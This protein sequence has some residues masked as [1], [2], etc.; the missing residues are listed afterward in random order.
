MMKTKRFLRLLLMAIL[1][2]SMILIA[3]GCKKI[4]EEA[5]MSDAECVKYI[6]VRV[7]DIEFGRSK[8]QFTTDSSLYPTVEAEAGSKS[9]AKKVSVVLLDSSNK[10]ILERAYNL[11]PGGKGGETGYGDFNQGRTLTP[12][13]YK[14]EFYYGDLLFDTIDIKIE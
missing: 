5:T 4:A 14:F 11:P 9:C 3:L 10:I 7:S 6:S 12:G 2:I 13:N 8:T 1:T